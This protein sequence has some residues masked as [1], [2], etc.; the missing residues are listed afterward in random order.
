MNSIGGICG[1][2]VG[3]SSDNNEEEVLSDI[4]INCIV[5][6]S[7][8]GEDTKSG[9]FV[10]TCFGAKFINCVS[11]VNVSGISEVGGFIGHSN[12]KNILFKNCI[13]TGDVVGSNFVGGFAGT[14]KQIP[15]HFMSHCIAS[16]VPQ[17][18]EDSI[19][20]NIGAFIGDKT[21]SNIKFA[22]FLFHTNASEYNDILAQK[23]DDNDLKLEDKLTMFN[24]NQVFEFDQNNYYPTIKNGAL[25]ETKWITIDSKEIEKNSKE[26]TSDDKVIDGGE[27]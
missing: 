26:I 15:D 12:D 13:S 8:T 17:L 6:G 20:D 23:I 25:Y 16:G 2:F 9:G 18:R 7:L 1:G 10:G 14:F 3:T 22:E 21:L 27:F 24:F 11:N 4:F 19:S 5:G